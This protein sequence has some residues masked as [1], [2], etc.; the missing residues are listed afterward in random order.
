[1]LPALVQAGRDA[2][3]AVLHHLVPVGR[4]RA[5]GAAAA[6][7]DELARRL[8]GLAP[9]E[10]QRALL[11]LVRQQV[12]GVLGHASAG[13]FEG[14]RSFKDLGFDSLTAV[15]LRNRLRAA[16]GIA[17]PATLVFDHPN[18][19][20]LVSFLRTQ[21]AGE[22]AT[23]S[24][25]GSRSH[26]QAAPADEPIAIVGMGCRFPGGADSP[27]AL[28][29]LVVSGGD[30]ITPFPADRGWDASALDGIAA[31]GGFVV[32]AGDFDAELFGIS[33]REALAMDPQQRLLLE[34][35]WEALE[36]AGIDPTSLRGT[37]TGVFAGVSANGYGGHLH[38]S[39]AETAGYLLT[40]STP[41]V[42]SGRLSYVFGLEGPAVSVD[43]ACSSALVAVHLAAQALRSGEC[44]MA[45][46]GGATVMANP[47]MFLEFARQG[48]LAG[49]GR[50]KSFADTADGTGW[51]EGAGMIVVE[52][53]A[54]A[55]RLG[56]PVLAV[57]RGSAINQDGASNG[58][59]APN[60]PS[61][62]RVI[63]Q[64]LAAARLEPSE[65]DAVEA[66]GTGTLLGDPIEAQALLATY[67]QS[68]PDGEPLWLGSVKSNLG[69]PQAAA[70]VAGIV[71]MVMALRAETLPRT[72]HSDTRS[73]HVDWESGG[74]ELLTEQRHWPRGTRPRRAGISSFGISGTNAHVII[75]EAPEAAQ[76]LAASEPSSPLPFLPWVLSGRSPEALRAQLAGLARHIDH[77]DADPADIGLSLAVTRA[78]LEQRA[79]VL[80]RDGD[81]LL[82][83]LTEPA[84]TGQVLDGR[85]AWMFTGQGSQRPR[86]GSELYDSFPVFADALDEVCALLDAELG[87]A[88]PLMEVMH[89]D[90][91][92]ALD[93]T[94]YAQSALFALQVATV[95][96]LRSWGAEP[97]VV[98]GH[99][100][101][102]FAAAHAAGVLA[103]PDAV[104]L[105]AARARLM[106]A[107]P[108]GGA[109]A[110]IE[111]SEAEI[112]E[113]LDGDDVT[114]A[115]VNGPT[116]VVVSG[117][118]DGVERVMAAVR[119]RGQ[120]TTR[121]RVSHAFHS[122]LMEPMLAEFARIAEEIDY[123]SPTCTA[124][125][126]VTGATLADGDWTSADYWVRQVR[127]PVRFHA[128]AEAAM[129]GQGAVR[130][131]EIGPDPVLSG[132]IE[133]TAERIA[134]SVLR[135]GRAEPETLLTAVAELF[136]RGADLD[137]RAVFAGTGARRVP[138]PTY[139]FQRRRYWV[140]PN[141]P[142][143]DT[144]GHPLLT[145][146][147]PVAGSDALLL[148]SRLSTHTHPWLAEHVV[149]GRVLV[150]GTALLEL[151]LQ[152]AHRV[153]Y[154]R[155]AELVLQAPLVLPEDGTVH[156][157]IAVDPP[158]TTD[159][160]EP[161]DTGGVLPARAVRIHARPDDSLPDTPWTLQA[162][163]TLTTEPAHPDWDLRIWPPT[164][165]EPL[166]LDGM[167][168]DLAETGLS[169]G[170]TFRGLSRAWRHGDDLYVEAEL[171]EPGAAEAAD[172]ALHPAL[173]DT[174]LHA[175]A[176]R[177]P[178]AGEA[179][180]PFLWSGVSLTA[181]GAGAVRA[182]LAPVRDGEVSLRVSDATG[183]PI[184]VVESLVLRPVSVTVPRTADT[185]DHLYRL[186]W[187]PTP[188]PAE[189]EDGTRRWA[190]LSA[191]PQVARTWA[192]AGVVGMT[193]YAGL[194]DLIA[195]LDEDTDVP[196]TVVLTLAGSGAIT[197]NTGEVLGPIAGLL[198]TMQTWLA[199]D[200]LTGSRLVVT[201]TDAVPAGPAGRTR[202]T[203]PA[204]AAAWGLVRSAINEHPGRFALADLDDDP[205]S[206]RAL[207]HHLTTGEVTQL[208]LREGEAWVPRLARLAIADEV[209]SVAAP[210]QAS[211][212]VLV[213]GGT[214]GLGAEVA[215]HLVTRHGV[216]DLLLVSRRGL[217]APGAADLVAELGGLGARVR[218]E[219]CDVS[220][221]DALAAVLDGVR[222]SGVVH[223]AG[224]LDDGLVADLTP[225][226]L[227]RVLAAKAESALHLH[228]LTAGQDLGAF[229][230]FSSFAG[231]VGNAG[232][233][234][235]A[236]ANNVLDALAQLRR[237][238]GLPA[239]SL[240]W[241]MWEAGMGGRMSDKDV[242]RLRRQGFPPLGVGE[243]LAL[244]DAALLVNEPVAVP[245]ALRLP[246]LAAGRD[247]LPS[248]LRDLVPAMSGRR[249]AVGAVVSHNGEGLV[250]RLRGLG[251]AERDRAVLEAV[252]TQVAAVLGHGAAGSV[253]PARAFKEL[254]F[255]SLTAVDLRNRLNSVTGLQLPATLIFDHP[256]VAEMAAQ[257]RAELDRAEGG[258]APSL[259]D[260]D[261]LEALVLAL[262]DRDGAA[263]K[264]TH[265]RLRAMV[266]RL[267][268]E[269]GAAGTEHDN[270]D[271]DSASLDSMFA[272]I[273][274]ELEG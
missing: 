205:A 92:D 96:L 120:R 148:T 261:R 56:H 12:A 237:S 220:D 149:A 38:E 43:T 82:A 69:H 161:T 159:S 271:I 104:R 137:W 128:A 27:D 110:A 9:A 42:A 239:V 77:T 249:K 274:R 106:R 107:L 88:Q 168:E 34:T 129:T 123:G 183:E 196:D 186:T 113:L 53:L 200:R 47:G 273:D 230:L 71:K 210:W 135:T 39:N 79:V 263:R 1:H 35:A 147:V 231:I 245:V 72:L 134:V 242:A 191:D 221:R 66:H 59:T 264:E 182:H 262:A 21:F 203:A 61:Q 46:A 235:Y 225:E 158:E 16:T 179:L 67:G 32:D 153:G 234:A 269:S 233:A 36:D 222:L 14:T 51:A 176:R 73:T 108:E 49:D 197:G 33:P 165:A 246:A 11:E 260:L 251:A 162:T 177:T 199:D 256:T 17:L 44:D 100:A 54:D 31:V 243:A 26:V 178:Q 175:L 127:E 81:E 55:Q 236:A 160:R 167:Y 114:I 198:G 45:L 192:A 232:Q 247:G 116:A 181:D 50:C 248:V 109:M 90:D 57:V 156:V 74:V 170:P 22:E 144:D 87:F 63:R 272:I 268:D 208:A 212:T 204:G 98:L 253:D 97:E 259:A 28:W 219:A 40:G 7:G 136:V 209:P 4:R 187:T 124:V 250:E 185:A 164:G 20:A 125:S 2:L 146:T 206:C 238:Q 86:M 23:D 224:V 142:R 254:G 91:A 133:P 180:L 132:R 166:P 258:S 217:Q 141:R 270:G 143:T 19:T 155:V 94:G 173:L 138:L 30:A 68:R 216:E 226:R 119:E 29:D 76:D 25:V 75:E 184:A 131:L 202:A 252:R 244:M 112:A 229:V 41:S 122:P 150:P 95:R 101:G 228:E 89:G 58:L 130:L 190:L 102:E 211:G 52:R 126:T 188:A 117:R 255:D 3:P 118:E 15:D 37:T 10:R 223:A 85:T 201:T 140:R 6:G 189:P 65:V 5:A 174:V 154:D 163:A 193:S 105:V 84:V 103:L 60:G 80:G 70:G 111:G 145:A 64:A 139:A 151:A 169:Y 266:V 157:Q 267:D 115:A 8:Q 194:A 13:A 24:A 215:R 93:D 152:A 227:A 83:G 62:Q 257:V 171:P 48:G 172:Y 213:T 240:A 214:G 18:P 99:S 78:T 265:E 207:P 121:L 218:I 241:G 195:T